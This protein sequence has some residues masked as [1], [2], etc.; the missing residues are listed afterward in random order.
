[1]TI[2]RFTGCKQTEAVIKT[3]RLEG[4]LVDT[5]EFAYCPAAVH[6][7][8]HVLG[9]RF[10]LSDL[11]LLD[12]VRNEKNHKSSYYMAPKLAWL[13]DQVADWLVQFHHVVSKENQG[14]LST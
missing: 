7:A 5:G 9:L 13:R 3:T 1:M 4:N 12:G 10:L 6:C 2:A 8:R 14:D 11:G